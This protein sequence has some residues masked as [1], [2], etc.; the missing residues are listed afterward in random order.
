MT[1]DATTAGQVAALLREMVNVVERRLQ[2][3]S[4][5]LVFHDAIGQEEEDPLEIS[6]KSDENSNNRLD[7]AISDESAGDDQEADDEALETVSV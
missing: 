4:P 5:P 3:L 2:P 6:H 7:R 1:G